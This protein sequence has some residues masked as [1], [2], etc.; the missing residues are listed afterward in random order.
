MVFKSDTTNEQKQTKTLAESAITP[1]KTSQPHLKLMMEDKF[2]QLILGIAGAIILG[3]F[4]II[5]Y[6]FSQNSELKERLGKVE[7]AVNFE[8]YKN[9]RKE[10]DE[11]SKSV[12][13]QNNQQ[14]TEKIRDVEKRLGENIER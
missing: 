8:G 14:F 13:S 7:V 5:W 9:L 3:I 10:V 2:L 1:S 11:L 4:T 6:L 12:G